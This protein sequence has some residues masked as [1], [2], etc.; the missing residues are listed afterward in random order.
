VS[1]GQPVRVLLVD[2]SRAVRIALRRTLARLEGWSE[3]QVS[4][5]EDG[6]QALTAIHRDRPDLVISDWN[7]P[8]MSGLELLRTLRREGEGVRFGIV[9]SEATPEVRALAAAEGAAFVLAKPFTPSA[10][11]RALTGVTED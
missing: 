4:E 2:D 5:A 8:G 6:H 3:A 9:T 7:M 10:L 1:V 11:E